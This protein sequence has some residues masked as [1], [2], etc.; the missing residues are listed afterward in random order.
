M[1]SN[2]NNHFENLL[3]ILVHG[4][5]HIENGTPTKV[6]IEYNQRTNTKIAMLPEG[7]TFNIW[8]GLDFVPIISH[9]KMFP[10]SAAVEMAWF[11]MGTQDATFMIERNK[12][13]Q[14]FTE[15]NNKTI[16]AAY[17]YRWRTHF[18]RDQIRMAIQALIL[19]PTDRRIWI[20]AWDPSIDGL[21]MPNQKNVPC[22]VGF[23]LNI[24]NGRLNSTYVKRS[25]DIFVGLP[26]DI[27]CHA[28]LMDAIRHDIDPELKLGNMQVCLAHPHL[29]EPH[30]KTAK[31]SRKH[32][33]PNGPS[34]KLPEFSLRFVEG[35][36]N[37]YV[38]YVKKMCMDLNQTDFH[39]LPEIIK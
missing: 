25:T 8:L 3:S 10:Y 26:Y 5:D 35:Y 7:Y 30:W 11:M 13:W 6:V 31:E 16:E 28:Y 1:S 27:M 14:K 18:G 2:F 34:L 29:Y 4:I 19:N 15:D 22:P 9:R 39:P 24:A 23:T 36:A 21:G 33:N 32:Y 17:G 38:D 12:F 20:S 37:Q